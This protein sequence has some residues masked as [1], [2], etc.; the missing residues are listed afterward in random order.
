M[1]VLIAG[2]ACTAESGPPRGAV[3]PGATGRPP[4]L[5]PL[6]LDAVGDV[7]PQVGSVAERNTYLDGMMLAVAVINDAGGVDGRPLR[8]AVHDDGGDAAVATHLLK[9]LAGTSL[10]ILYAG[11]GTGLAPLR[12][13]L[14]RTG[15]PVVLL[16]GDLYTT[17]QLF[18]EVFQT[19]IPWAWQ[20]A[21]IARYI[22]VDRRAQDVVFLGTGPE[23]EAAV[24]P[25][26]A[27]LAY[28]GGSLG[29]AFT[30]RSSQ[31]R[32]GLT[33]A[34][35]RAARA[36]AVVAFGP[37]IGDPDNGVLGNVN[38]VE[39]VASRLPSISASSALLEP[40]RGLAHPEPGA[41]ACYTYTWAGW[42]QPIKRVAKFRRLFFRRFG[43]TPNGLEQEGYDAVRVV[44]EG[45]KA[46]GGVGGRDL[47]DALER[48]PTQTFSSFPI[49][50]GPDDHLFLPRD[51]LG[52]FAV[53][54]RTQRLDPWQS[55]RQP[56][57]MP[58]MRTFTYDGKRTNILDRDKRVFFPFWRKN[59]PAPFYWKSRY[60]I[61]TKAT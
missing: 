43:R 3:S 52:L 58:L 60:G 2:S 17:R 34:L 14:D 32:T 59:R 4:A 18:R 11:P 46:T 51:E 30:E 15:T 8:L 42:A 61:T 28:W 12:P 16:E 40:Y 33:D 50:F 22:I 35:N 1:A 7:T 26:R 5:Q 49:D 19:T 41:S 20:V 56:N 25:T 44:A 13:R 45:L 36:D 23:A 37:A 29:A 38:A 39:E 9:S 27:A 53:P 47:T 21:V 54:G 24:D 6:V 31:S 48:L 55:R 57:W 10:A